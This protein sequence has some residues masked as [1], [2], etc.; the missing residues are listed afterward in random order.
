[1]R[2]SGVVQL[3]IASFTS[4]QSP[5]N[6]FGAKGQLMSNQEDTERKKRPATS[7]FIS[8]SPS[9][10]RPLLSFGCDDKK[11]RASRCQL[12]AF[13][14]QQLSGRSAMRRG[15]VVDNPRL[16]PVLP[17]RS[18]PPCSSSKIRSL[19]NSL[20]STRRE[21]MNSRQRSKIHERSSPTTMRLSSWLTAHGTRLARTLRVLRLCSDSFHY[22]V[23]NPILPNSSL[24]SP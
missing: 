19:V 8:P 20:R 24:I 6:G 2:S 11:V 14:C 22:P 13:M 5:Q 18:I 12:Q 10:K 1:M 15:I 3:E 21:Y 9:V 7:P 23:D 4:V 17:C 16:L